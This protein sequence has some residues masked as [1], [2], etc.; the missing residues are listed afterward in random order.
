MTPEDWEEVGAV[1]GWPGSVAEL[2]EQKDAEVGLLRF[3]W[4][5]LGPISWSAAMTLVGTGRRRALCVWDEVDSYRA[6]AAV[7]PWDDPV[8]VSAAATAYLSVNGTRHGDGLFGSLP[9]EV[10]NDSP[11][12]LPAAVVARALF[13]YME[14]CESVVPGAWSML[15]SE[16]YGRMVEPNHLQRCLDIMSSFSLTDLDDH[17]RESA[18]MSI[19]ARQRLF[20]EWWADAYDG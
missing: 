14:W 8:A 1:E 3:Y 10:S 12:L 9:H 4:D 11:F 20:G 19:E 13:D 18:R 7:E 15:A 6:V 17:A 16:H 5:G 2:L